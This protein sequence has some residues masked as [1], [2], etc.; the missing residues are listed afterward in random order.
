MKVMATDVAF[1]EMKDADEAFAALISPSNYSIPIY[2]PAASPV[3]PLLPFSQPQ[4]SV[5][6]NIDEHC[7]WDD[8]H[9]CLLTTAVNKVWGEMFAAS[10][11][12]S[13][14]CSTNWPAS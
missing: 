5:N 1:E 14:I 3:L 8:K 11:F 2:I 4:T 13:F 10:R 9:V 12:D 6:M 7:R